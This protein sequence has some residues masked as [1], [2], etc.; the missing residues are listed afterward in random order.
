MKNVLVITYYWPPSGGGGVQRWLKF[1][2]YLPEEGW[3]CLVCT[4]DNPAF[5]LVDPGL[6]EDVHPDTEVLKIPI[7]EPYAIF[8]RMK[9]ESHISQ[10]VTPKGAGPVSR[11][12]RGNFFIPDPRKFWIRPAVRFLKQYLKDRPVDL[13]ITT[14]PPHSMH[15]IGLKLSRK[16]GIPW[17]ADFRD[18]WSR[19]DLLNEFKLTPLARWQHRRLEK[20]VVQTADGVITVSQEWADE[21]REMYGVKPKVITNGFDESD[22]PVPGTP[23]KEFQIVHA[24]LLNSYRHTPAI[25][26]ALKRFFEATDVSGKII[27]RGMIDP[28]VR[29]G[30]R[31]N[32]LGKILDIAPSIPHKEVVKL[33]QEAGLLLLLMNRSDNSAGHIPGKLFEYLAVNRWI[34]GIGDPGG[35]TASILENTGAGLVCHWDDEEGIYEALNMFYQRFFEGD[36]PDSTLTGKYSRKNLTS[37]LSA[38]LSSVA[39]S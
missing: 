34:L 6:E 27:L 17:I 1:T 21:F 28:D 22:F 8:K 36:L 33:Y 32:S 26:N 23:A 18:P 29:E 20:K 19:W 39:G 37:E 2:K 3:H 5:D 35:A 24:G 13:I 7:W 14:G 9:G 16:L 11:F 15:L 4:P 30:L 25:W 38:Y 31:K 10:G 12:I